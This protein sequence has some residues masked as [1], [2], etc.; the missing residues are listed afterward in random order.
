MTEL[1]D[2]R[3]RLAEAEEVLRAIRNGEVDGV[4]VTGERGE[5]VYTL[6]GADR[7]YRQLI[8]TMSEGAVTVSADGVILYCNVRLAEM[9]GR[10]LDRVMG[11]A[12]R[13]YLPPADQQ[14]LDAIL[15]QART[16]PSRRE[17][18]LKSSEGRLVP[19][20]LSASRLPGEEA[21]MVFCL[22]FTD[23][24]EQKS[25][26]HL[27]EEERRARSILEQAAEATRIDIT[28]R[29]QADVALRSS[30][31]RFRALIEH[32]ADFISLLALDGT[33]LWESPSA[34]RPLG[35]AP[36]AFLGRNA[37]ELVHPDD[38]DRVRQVLAQAVQQ[39]AIPQHG[40]FRLL[41]HDGAWIWVEGS[42]TN[43]LH[44]ESVRAIVVNYR[45]VTERKQ[46][47]AMLRESEVRYRGLFEANPQPLW[48]YDLE[49]LAFLQV[50]DAAVAHYG[51]RRDEFLTMTI[52]E[53]RPAE[54]AARL[55][56][57]IAHFDDDAMGE[58]SVWRHRKKDGSTIDVEITSHAV[59]HGGRRARLVLAHD[60]T[61]RKRA[62]E[63]L[64]LESAALQAAPDAIVITDR[65]GVI[66]WVNPAFIQLT[67]Y[68]A[69]EALGKNPR[70][71]FKSGKHAPA[72]YQDLW[73]TILAGRTWHGEMIN[74]RK[75]GSLYTE[76]QVV[77]P[78]PDASGAITHFIAIKKDMTERLQLEAQF[79][80]A[81]KMDSVGQLASGIAHDFNNLLTVINGM[82]ELL[83]AQVR[84]DDPMSADVQEI[85]RAGERAATLTQQLLA[86]SRQQI[87]ETRVMSLNTVVTGME[88]LLRRLLGEDIDLMVVLTPGLGNVKAD[89]GQ[90]E[91]VITNLAVNARDAMPQGGRLT[92]ET[93]SVMVDKDYAR[94]LGVTSVTMPSG[95]YVLLAVSDS[96]SGMDEATR[97]RIFEP[98]FTTKGPGKGTGLGLS[99]V[100][101][102]VKQSHGFVWVYSEVGQGTS[103]KIYL[104]RV[105]EV[106]GPDQP[107]PTVVS[108]S[109]TETILLAEDNAGL[110]RLAT[111]LLAPA[112]Y[113]VLGAASGEEA[114]RLLERHDA[115]VHLLLSDVVMPG[116][117]GRDL[118]EHLA[119]TRPEIKVLYMSG[120]TSD[121][122]VRHG[123]LE[124]QV[125]FL[126]KP[127]TAAA[128]LRKVREV[129]DS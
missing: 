127:F 115:P 79:R 95:S 78:I 34:V 112:G 119:Q 96:G 97:T 38:A 43:L 117:S 70:D 17:I 116:M 18:N 111:R 105:T 65:A 92:I 32:G 80:Q 72:F 126:N 123:V 118:A 39:P 91:Q 46:A 94:Q 114:L 54:D 68:T 42:A 3:A 110:R 52:A 33:L 93:Q 14:A 101:G 9:L 73:E 62:E 10:P 77:T 48:V 7:I 13:N 87:L 128:L 103:F 49:T 82:S 69:E 1:E 36:D 41:R 74:R 15:A 76:E 28:Q 40:V 61:A 98:F 45:D 109:G 25:H 50:N 90:I 102:I 2:L 75:D 24:T 120:Y 44:D 20:Y 104:P 55:L 107:G 113:T 99:T 66:Q 86:F 89:P 60:I 19:V 108:N 12:L 31:K 57:D 58:G 84:P 67:G 121:T 83:L 47:E 26:E 11:T 106:A 21:E 129:L 51:Y 16:E 30:E 85:R 56:A 53:I 71:L 6:L 4:L 63:S 5:Q 35:Y 88:S 125:P 59:D 8:E 81:Q 100:Y 64:R 22:V 23:L 37:L 122:I 27:V 29:K 124:A